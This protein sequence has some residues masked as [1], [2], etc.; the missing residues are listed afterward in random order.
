MV[1]QQ[2]CQMTQKVVLAS[3][4]E[5]RKRLLSSAG[6]SFEAIAAVLDE[7]SIRQSLTLEGAAPIEMSTALA[8]MKALRVSAQYNEH[9]VIGCD[10]ILE[11]DGKAHGKARD[12]KVAKKFLQILRGKTHKLHSASVICENNIPIWR[13]VSSAEVTF[14]NF[15]DSYIDNYLQRGG[16]E[17]LY[18]VGCYRIEEEGIRLFASLTGDIYAVYGIPMIALLGYLMERGFL[19]Y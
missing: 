11:F 7:E 8:E 15:S 4:S 14:R 2:G 9:L 19:E 16:H 5:T 10:Q 17:L 13:A 12:L 3:A 1:Y 6:V 18:N